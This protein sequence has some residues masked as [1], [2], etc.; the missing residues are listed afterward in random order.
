MRRR[1]RTQRGRRGK[2]SQQGMLAVSPERMAEADG[3]GGQWQRL[4]VLELV[5]MI[6]NVIW[7]FCIFY[8]EC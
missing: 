7:L 5:L 1:S 3:E 4:A 2:S 8:I 6:T